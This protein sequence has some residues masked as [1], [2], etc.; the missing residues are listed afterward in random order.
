MVLTLILCGVAVANA[1]VTAPLRQS[2]A[3][4]SSRGSAGDI[5]MINLFGNNEE[6]QRRR[7]DLSKRSAG[8]GDRK[9]RFRKPNQATTGLLLGIK[10][11]ESFSKAVIIDKII[12]GTEADSLKKQ[13]KLKEGDE[14]TMVSATF[15]DE[16]WSARGIGKIRLEKS[17]AVRQGMFIDFVVENNNDKNN[18]NLG[19]LARK[20]QEKMNR[21]QKQLQAEVDA[22]NK[23]KKFGF[24]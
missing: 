12:P 1:F 22:E 14:I 5:R 8:V 17:I 9:V 24:F 4:C 10:F 7:N 16:M 11:K 21:L 3:V 6:S 2:H 15:G 13:G 23:K 20:E 19:E 18:K